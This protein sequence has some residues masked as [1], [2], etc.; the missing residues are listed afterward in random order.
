MSAPTK[1]LL[2]VKPE[3]CQ[4]WLVKPMPHDLCGVTVDRLPQMSGPDLFAV[5]HRGCDLSKTG[6]WDWR[7]TTSSRT[8]K[9]LALHRFATLDDAVSAYVLAGGRK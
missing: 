7:P 6:E 8:E 5:H 1:G 2:G 4:W 9:W 3:P